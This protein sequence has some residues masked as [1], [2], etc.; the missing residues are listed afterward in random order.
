[1]KYVADNHRHLKKVT[2]GR[3]AVAVTEAGEVVGVGIAGSPW[4][5]WE[6]TGRIVITRVATNG[7]RNACS[8]IYR[9]LTRAAKA[10][11]YSEVWTYTLTEESGASLR[12]A[13][14]T[15]AG[16]TD[17]GEH[18]RPARRRRP[19]VRPEPKKRWVVKFEGAD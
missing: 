19:A 12:G 4:Q 18:D 7:A 3:F 11:A 17:G 6:G 1:M 5:E 15:F 16:M 2:G 9:S 14:F 13:G 8:M 10:L